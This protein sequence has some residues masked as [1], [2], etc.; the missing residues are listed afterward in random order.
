VSSKDPVKFSCFEVEVFSSFCDVMFPVES[1]VKVQP[2]I[3]DCFCLWYGVVPVVE[4]E[5]GS[6]S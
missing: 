4:L 6:L 1:L 5:G 2:K 3:F